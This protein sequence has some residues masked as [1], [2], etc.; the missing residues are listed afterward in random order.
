MNKLFILTLNWN[1][2]NHLRNLYPSLTKSLLDIDYTWLIKD[3]NS[4]DNSI[5]YIKSLN[6]ERIKLVEYKNNLHNFSQGCNLLFNEANPNDNDDILLLNND[7]IFNDETSLK[8]MISIL[9]NDNNVGV[10]GARLIYTNTNQLQHAGVVFDEKFKNPL[11]YRLKEKSDLNAT[12]NRLFQS[13]TGAALLTKASYYKNVC[14]NEKSGNHGMDEKY[15]WGFDDV[16]LCLSIK[17]NMNKDIVYCGNTNIYHEDSA[18]LKKTPTNKLF[19]NHNLNHLKEK[20]ND[21][22]YSDYDFYKKNPKYNLYKA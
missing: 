6:D 15:H 10:V 12:K 1:G 3:N 5:Q 17:Y 4:S 9:H 22:C 7:I 2:E 19:L 14:Y 8:N 16:D 20:W 21:K 11:H 18:S 13:V